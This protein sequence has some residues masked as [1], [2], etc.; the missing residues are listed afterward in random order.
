MAIVGPSGVGKSTLLRAIAGLAAV[1]DGC[2]L[3]EGVDVTERPPEGRG[4]VYLHQMPVLFPHL[5][6]GENVA[7]PLRVRGQRGDAVRQRVREALSAVRLD[8]F[9]SRPAHTLSGGQRHRAA[10]ARAIAARPAVLLLD[11]PLSA[12]DPALRSDVGAAIVAAQA[13]YR[14][15]MLLVSHDL[16]DVAALAD[17]VA[18][19]LDGA[20]AQCTEPEVLFSRPATLAVARFLGIYQE[21]A[22]HVRADGAISCA[23]GVIDIPRER[24]V[25]LPAGSLVT[26]CFRAESVRLRPADREGRNVFATVVGMRHRPRGSTLVLQVGEGAAASLIEAAVAARDV[27]RDVGDEVCVMLDLCGVM[28][29]PS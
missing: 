9:E 28:V 15:A 3:V 22:G 13:E 16:D 20:I 21:L 17:R 19:L 14:P 12:L 2:V 4:V 11:E 7:F 8:A 26:L 5:S 25:A 24:R 29:Y 23:L 10:L 18:I 27:A 1:D 6:V